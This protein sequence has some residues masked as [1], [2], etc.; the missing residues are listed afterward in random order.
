MLYN[1]KKEECYEF[2]TCRQS[3][4]NNFYNIYLEKKMWKYYLKLI[5]TSINNFQ[6]SLNLI[7]MGF[8]GINMCS[9]CRVI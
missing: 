6:I 3:T 9:G 2:C 5:R 1:L 7:K 4:Y 8:I